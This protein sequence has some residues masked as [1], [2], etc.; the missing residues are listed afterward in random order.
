MEI[1]D[2]NHFHTTKKSLV[3]EGF[4]SQIRERAEFA[5]WM[6]VEFKLYCLLSTATGG[7]SGTSFWK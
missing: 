4:I 7:F 2:W 6:R 3:K 5:L 1:R